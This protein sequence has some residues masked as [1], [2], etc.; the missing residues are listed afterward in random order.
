MLDNVHIR[1]F[2]AGAP[3]LP[4]GTWNVRNVQSS[5]WRLY[6]NDDDGAYVDHKDDRCDLRAGQFYFLPAGVRFDCANTA[7]VRHFYVHFDVIGIPGMVM[8]E[9]FSRPIRVGPMAPEIADTAAERSG[10]GFEE[11]VA[12]VRQLR[13]KAL[14][15]AALAE[16][17]ESLPAPLLAHFGQ[18]TAALTRVL[19]AIE[20]IEEHIA[21]PLGNALLSGL[22]HMS[23]AHFIRTF[24]AAVGTSPGRYVLERR[25]ALA[26]QALLFTESSIEQIAEGLGF[27]NRFYFSRV[28]SRQVGT[29]PA[30]FRK[31]RRV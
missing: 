7:D 3:L 31:S 29:S 22:C 14:I 9:V 17:L 2:V 12:V 6:R 19:P 26:E 10:L 11:T 27:G 24:H 16:Y 20:H 21:E 4:A 1:I 15:Y 8:R 18:F 23:G 13:I 30:A 28:F 25:I 5:F